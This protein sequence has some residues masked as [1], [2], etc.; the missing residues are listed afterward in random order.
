MKKT[1]PVDNSY[2]KVRLVLWGVICLFIGFPI[3]RYGWQG[4]SQNQVQSEILEKTFKTVARKGNLIL[5]IPREASF[6]TLNPMGIGNKPTSDNSIWL[7]VGSE[8]EVRD[9]H[10][11]ATYTVQ[12]VDETGVVIHY[13]ADGSPPARVRNSEGDVRLDWK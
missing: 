8:F 12:S 3:V 11:S 2:F 5:L 13:V 9:V 7:S 1:R 4:M 10:F 6:V